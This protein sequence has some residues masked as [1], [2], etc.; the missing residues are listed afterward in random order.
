MFKIR[1]GYKSILLLALI[2]GLSFA[3]V[4]AQKKINYGLTVSPTATWFKTDSY[5]NSK[6]SGHILGFEIGPFIRIR[7]ADNWRAKIGVLYGNR[8]FDATTE[9]NMWTD[10]DFSGG[11]VASDKVTVTPRLTYIKFPIDIEHEIGM[12]GQKTTYL[13]AGGFIDVLLDKKNGR[14]DYQKN[15]QNGFRLVTTIGRSYWEMGDYK[16]VE[17]GARLGVG[18]EFLKIKKASMFGE[19]AMDYEFRK[20]PKYSLAFNHPFRMLSLKLGLSF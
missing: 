10:H 13:T 4:Q 16:K 6:F 12:I 2:F 8:G 7:P 17:I 18:M 1:S 5:Y 20:H 14:I 3:C 19:L 9:V 11:P 15:Y